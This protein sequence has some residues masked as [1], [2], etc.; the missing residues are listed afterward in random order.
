MDLF[1]KLFN[2][3]KNDFDRAME[4]AFGEFAENNPVTKMVKGKINEASDLITQSLKERIDETGSSDWE[5]G[6]SVFEDFGAKSREWNSMIEKIVSKELGQYKVCP[7]C[8]EA[9]PAEYDICPYCNRRLPENT[10]DIWICPHCGSQNRDLEFFCENCG[11][12]LIPAD[13]TE[14]KDS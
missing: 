6:P 3:E 1:D 7:G 11:K 12:E 4:K 9:V 14:E 5:K 8:H 2:K 13:E 10:A